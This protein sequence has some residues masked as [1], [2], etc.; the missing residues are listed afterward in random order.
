MDYLDETP[1]EDV[2]Q[3][4]M[5]AFAGAPEYDSET[6]EQGEDPFLEE[7]VRKYEGQVLPEDN[8]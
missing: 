1:I 4:V 3:D 6:H 2:Q 8:K 7:D 5:E